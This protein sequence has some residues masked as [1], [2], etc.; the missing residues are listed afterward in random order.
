MT[1]ATPERIRRDQA[2]HAALTQVAALHRREPDPVHSSF[3]GRAEYR[4]AHCRT[5]WPCRTAALLP[6]DAGVTR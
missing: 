4:C 3:T 1:G 5:P 6:P 2:L